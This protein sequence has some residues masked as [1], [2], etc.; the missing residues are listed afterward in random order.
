MKKNYV[1]P[2]AVVVSVKFDKHLLDASG[3]LNNMNRGTQNP[4]GSTDGWDDNEA[5]E[6]DFLPTD[7]SI[8]SNEEIHVFCTHDC[9]YFVSVQ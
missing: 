2:C 6:F 5:K 3:N 7:E 1:R 4:F 9:N 8:Y